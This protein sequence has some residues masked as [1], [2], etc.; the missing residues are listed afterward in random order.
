LT[1]IEESS[2]GNKTILVTGASGFIGKP[3][4]KRLEQAGCT[5]IRHSEHRGDIASCDLPKGADHVFHL[6]A[7]TFVPDSW[8]APMP[9][10]TTNVLGTVNV[11]EF[12]RREG[13]SLTMMS[14][15]VYGRPQ[16]LP[17]SETHPVAAFNPYSHT[18]LLAEEVCRYYAQQFD[19]RVTVIRPFNIYGPGQN[20]NFLIPTLLRQVLDHEAREISIAD[21]RPRRDY[22]YVDELLDLLV[23]TMDPHGFEIFNAGSGRSIN[24]RE[25]AE[26][27]LAAAAAEKRVVSRGEVRPDEVLETVADVGKAKRVFGW[28][29]HISLPDGLGRMINANRAHGGVP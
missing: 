16:F 17:I 20:G 8:S 9:F 6:A 19:M 14:S 27:M 29:P 3:L 2:L 4:A 15:Y 24:P 25:L 11:A 13:A 28:E 1:D 7:R 26:S 5:V 22:L 10:Y 18:K 23:L 21:D 12:C